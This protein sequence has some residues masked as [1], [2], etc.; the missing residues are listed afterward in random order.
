MLLKLTPIATH[1]GIPDF[2]DPDPYGVKALQLEGFEIREAGTKSKPSADVFEFKP[3][4]TSPVYSNYRK[5]VELRGR[6]NSWRGSMYSVASVDKSTQTEQ[7]D[8]EDCRSPIHNPRRRLSPPLSPA[9]KETEHV[10][11][12]TDEEGEED[13]DQ[14]SDLKSSIQ[15]TSHVQTAVPVVARAR[16]VQV[17]KRIPPQLPPRN[18]NRTSQSNKDEGGADG[19]DTISL[20]GSE[21]SD[22]TLEKGN[23]SIETDDGA[24]K[25]PQLSTDG[26]TH[27][28]MNAAPGWAGEDEFHS[29]PPSPATEHQR[30]IP[31][32][33]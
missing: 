17:A 12:S 33:F 2:E 23:S 4:T 19:F 28:G 18:P 11:E 29:V 27:V 32:A 16:V 21:R 10:Q 8:D 13:D 22:V 31:G 5:S 24:N 9:R 20:N 26:K 30:G 6:T 25:A 1:F 3:A 15:E 7:T 14:V